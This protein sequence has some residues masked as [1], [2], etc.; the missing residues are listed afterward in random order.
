M[1]SDD[2]R[3]EPV[4]EADLDLLDA[5]LCS[6]DQTGKH[7]WFGFTSSSAVRRR[8]EE[9]GLLSDDGGLLGVIAAGQTVGRVEWFKAAWGRPETSW[10]WTIAV[11]IYREHRGKGFGTEAHRQVVE[12]LFRHTRAARIQAYTDVENVAEQRAL[13]K[14]GFSKEGVLRFA[15][16]RD[17]GWHDQVLYSVVRSAHERGS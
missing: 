4:T 9:T 5:N 17:G 2:V 12:Y 8:F 7:Q 1:T 11:A 13:E 14:A 6:E 3:L 16:W 15:Q 10:C